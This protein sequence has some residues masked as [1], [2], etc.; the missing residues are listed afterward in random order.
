M[1]FGP[2]PGIRNAERNDWKREPGT[3]PAD[4]ALGEVRNNLKKTG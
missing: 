3:E 4:G 2:F 1:D